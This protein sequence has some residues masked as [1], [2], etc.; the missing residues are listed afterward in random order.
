ME[1][2]QWVELAGQYLLR[3]PHFTEPYT[4]IVNLAA[5]NGLELTQAQLRNGVARLLGA[6]ERNR[7]YEDECRAAGELLERY[8]Q[9]KFNLMNFGRRIGLREWLDS[10]YQPLPHFDFRK[11]MTVKTN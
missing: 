1:K 2:I 10:K 7:I 6:C 9:P 11:Q 5:Y 3:H 8:T 4:L